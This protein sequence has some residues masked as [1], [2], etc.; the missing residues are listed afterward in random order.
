MF[1]LTRLRPLTGQP[2]GSVPELAEDN[3]LGNFGQAHNIAANVA[4]NRVY[5][6]GSTYRNGGQDEGVCAGGALSVRGNIRYI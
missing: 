1:D 6:I 2:A 5:V 3:H 4:A